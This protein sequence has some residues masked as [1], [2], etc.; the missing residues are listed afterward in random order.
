MFR[1]ILSALTVTL[2]AGS[3]L[4]ACGSRPSDEDLTNAFKKGSSVTVFGGVTTIKYDAKKAKCVAEVLRDSDISDDT[5]AQFVKPTKTGK[6]T[7]E[8]KKALSAIDKKLQACDPETPNA[9]VLRPSVESVAAGFEKG[10]RGYAFG[11]KALAKVNAEKSMCL[12]EAL[13]KSEV[14]NLALAKMLAQDDEFT[15][16]AE[17]AEAFKAVSSELNACIK[18]QLGGTTPSP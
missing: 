7:S 14:S 12:A 10:L 17:D 16:S 11:S 2:V 3:V 13:E 6:A 18:P 1:R 9:L 5:L 15:A 4:T 8:D